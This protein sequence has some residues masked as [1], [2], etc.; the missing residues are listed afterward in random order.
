MDFHAVRGMEDDPP[1]SDLVVSTLDGQGAI[2]GEGPRR[3]ALLGEMRDE[4]G[5]GLLVESGVDEPLRSLLG[6]RGRQLSRE[7]AE[8]LAQLEGA[9]DAVAVPERHFARLPVGGDDVHAVVRDLGDAPTRG[10]QREHVADAGFVDHLLVELAHPRARGLARDEHAEQAAVGDGPSARHGDALRP[11]AAGQ[12][13]GVA[14]PHE[15]RAQLGELVGGEA[16]GEQVEGRLISRARQRLERRR[17]TNG[18]VPLLDPDLAEG[19]RRDGLLSQDVE[20]IARHLDGLDP[21]RQHPFGDD[22]RVQ[23]VSPVLGKERGAAD[24]AH[25][26]A[27]SPHAL[28]PRRGRR[29][30]LDLDHEVDRAHVDAQFEAARRHHAAQEPGLQLFFDL[31]AL[32]FRHRAVVSLGE[33]GVGSGRRPRLRHH[34]RGDRG[35]G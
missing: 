12:G 9:P 20:R 10:A 11:G 35:L 14:I 27:C 19:A 34:R 16:S 23:H 6:R 29:R 7:A 28:Q 22:G 32:L 26:V 5:P 21:A 2:G 8:R 15:T 24:L 17:S 4:V 1:V 30:G 31:G 33:H 18:L 3:L 25:L 13:A